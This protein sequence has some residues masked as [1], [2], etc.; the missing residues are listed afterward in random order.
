MVLA[1]GRPNATQRFEHNGQLDLFRRRYELRHTWRWNTEVR[2]DGVRV[3]L[4]RRRLG[5]PKVR[6]DAVLWNFTVLGEACNQSGQKEHFPAISWEKP[7]A[8][9]NR[10]VHGYWS[11]DHQILLDTVQ[12]DLPI[13]ITQLKRALADLS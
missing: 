1:N 2:C 8:M 5:R 10:V 4:L 7:I 13:L 3:A 11:A 9:R 12:D 6:V